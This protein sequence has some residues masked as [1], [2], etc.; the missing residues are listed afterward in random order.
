[1]KRFHACLS[2]LLIV[3]F[4]CLKA[5]AQEEGDDE[6]VQY[7]LILPEE[8][9]PELVKPEENNPFESVASGREEDDNSTEENQVRD[10]L[11]R[12]PVGGAASGLKGMRVMLGG[13]RLEPG[14][15]VPPV[16]PDQQVVLRVKSINASAIELVWVEKKPTGLP[17]KLLVIPMDGSPS[18]RYRMPNGATGSEQGGGGGGDMGTLRRPDVSAFSPGRNF[19]EPSVARAEPVEEQPR[20][21]AAPL[22]P[23][24]PA[25]PSSVK[26]PLPPANVPEASVMRMLFGNRPPEP[27]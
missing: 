27:K 20:P 7:T 11:L 14:M 2:A 8:K 12:M 26:P 18:V 21:A 17:P 9:T 16:I 10:L 1:M 23:P 4:P 3:S 24:P 22:A 25:A 13:M 6:R 15:D 5:T 19:E